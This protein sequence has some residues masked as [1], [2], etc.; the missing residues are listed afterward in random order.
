VAQ[1][2]S[3]YAMASFVIVLSATSY[4]YWALTSA[5]TRENAALLQ[6]RLAAISSLV[7]RG[8]SELPRLRER[9][10][11]EW[12]SR[13][14]GQVY[15]RAID[16]SG[17][18]LMESPG[19]P[20]EVGIEIFPRAPWVK[21]PERTRKG[22][23]EVRQYAKL[24]ANSGG[25]YLTVARKFISAPSGTITA[26]Y[27]ALDLGPSEQVLGSYRDRLIFALA[28]S[29]LLS[30]FFG[31]RLAILA[32]R[33]VENIVET[34]RKIRSSTLNERINEQPLPVELG[35]LAA[36]VNEMLDRLEEAFQRLSRF[37]ADI[38]HELRTPIN[39]IQGE[40]E[41]ALS[42]ARSETDY[43][44]VLGSCL[45]EAGRLKKLIDSL[46]FIA[47]SEDPQAHIDP[48]SVQ[49]REELLNIMDF[50]E[51]SASDEKLTVKVDAPAELLLE[52]DRTLFQRAVGN[53]IGNAISYNRP[54]GSICVA[55]CSVT[56]GVEVSVADTGQ[57]IPES[58]IP[59]VFDRFHRVDPSRKATKLGGFGLGLTIVKS[60]MTLHHG[61]IDIES[62][63]G[64]GTRV[65]LLFPG[66]RPP[67]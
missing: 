23:A 43:R 11:S 4:L 34:T 37:S 65:R 48:E 25:R 1:L 58:E 9:I 62:R 35:R 3:W 24:R 53:L 39:N 41:V 46:L 16:A 49:V 42:K 44:E 40:V 6:D 31:R 52:V 56:S 66:T 17:H 38:A 15:V 14:S 28:V 64:E 63:L 5:I 59:L 22:P 13:R 67:V 50:Y 36:T 55:A 47:K 60:I 33:P 10:S 8:E 27:L 26:V 54:G 29:L 21:D 12:P 45:E 7:E 30:I 2:T 32:F 18:T 20:E 51:A 61:R 19:M 57:G